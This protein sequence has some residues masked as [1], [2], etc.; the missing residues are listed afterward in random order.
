MGESV[1]SNDDIDISCS[2]RLKTLQWL[3]EQ[4]G[5]STLMMTDSS[6]LSDLILDFD[7]NNVDISVVS[8]VV[9]VMF[10]VLHRFSVKF[11]IPLA[12]ASLVVFIISCM[13]PTC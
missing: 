1:F 4:S 12:M 9:D 6:L 3:G 10:W 2:G 11:S 8:S 7:V 5:S 13:I